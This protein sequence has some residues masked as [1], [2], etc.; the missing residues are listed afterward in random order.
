MAD[1]PLRIG[2]GYI[3]IQPRLDREALSTFKAKLIKELETAGKAGSRA[4]VNG[5]RLGMDEAMSGVIN[6]TNRAVKSFNVLSTEVLKTNAKLASDRLAQDAKV[7]AAR[8]TASAKSQATIEAARI[9]SESSIAAQQMRIDAQANESRIRRAE[10]TAKAVERAYGQALAEETRRQA[11]A[12]SQMDAFEASFRRSMQE[13]ISV[14]RQAARVQQQEATRSL[15][16]LRS[17]SQAWGT[18]ASAAKNADRVNNDLNNALKEQSRWLVYTAE[19]IRQ[20]GNRLQSFGQ[21]WTGYVTTPILGAIAAM[22]SF[23]LQAGA[24]IQ[25]SQMGLAAIYEANG[26]G[27]SKATDIAKANLADLRSFAEK[28]SYSFGDMANGVQRL[29]AAGVR[30][31]TGVEWMKTLGNAAAVSGA[32]VQE[33]NRAII[34]VTQSMDAERINAQDMNQLQNAGIPIWMVLGKIYH[35]NR[36]ELLAMSAAGQLL[37]RDVWPKVMKFWDQAYGAK[38]GK[39]AMAEA[40]AG[41]VPLESLKNQWE[42]FKNQLADVVNGQDKRGNIIDPETPRQLSLLFKNL[43]SALQA[44]VPIFKGFLKDILPPLNAGLV[45]LKGVIE[46]LQQPQNEWIRNLVLGAAV[47]GPLALGAGLMFRTVGFALGPFG[48]L[49]ELLSKNKVE[50]GK[51][52]GTFGNL[53]GSAGKFGKALLYLTTIPAFARLTGMGVKSVGKGISWFSKEATAKARFVTGMPE[54]TISGPIKR[55]GG[56]LKEDAQDAKGFFGGLIS[57][58]PGMEKAAGLLS[59]IKVLIKSPWGAAA[60]TAVIAAIAALGV[61]LVGAWKKSENFRNGIKYMWFQ[62]RDIFSRFKAGIQNAFGGNASKSLDGFG[63][64]F[65]AFGDWLEKNV[66]W[67]VNRA[68]IWIRDNFQ[69]IFAGLVLAFQTVGNVVGGILG[70]ILSGLWSILKGLGNAVLGVA[71]MVWSM[72]K[73]MLAWIGFADSASGAT[74]QLGVKGGMLGK[75]IVLLISAF[76]GFGKMLHAV[77][78]TAMVTADVL[79]GLFGI[80]GKTAQAMGQLFQGHF[81]D[82]WNTFKSGFSG[83]KDQ[84]TGAIGKIGKA[85]TDAFDFKGIWDDSAS[86]FNKLFDAAGKGLGSPSKTKTPKATAPSD[87]GGDGLEPGPSDSPSSPSSTKPTPADKRRA[88]LKKKADAAKKRFEDAKSSLLDSFKSFIDGM[89]GDSDQ[90]KKAGDALVKSVEKAFDK[91]GRSKA[92]DQAVAYLK[93]VNARLVAIAKERDAIIQKVADAKD[94][95][96]TTTEGAQDT[97]KFGNLPYSNTTSGG[98]R[99]GLQERLNKIKQFVSVIKA[100]AKRGIDKGL[101]RQVVEMGP[102]DGLSLGQTLLAADK[103]TFKAIN[104]IQKQIDQA[105]KNL[106]NTASEMIFGS[107]KELEKKGKSLQDQ[108]NKIAKNAIAA[109]ARQFGIGWKDIRSITGAGIDQ[110]NKT[111][112]DGLT[113]SKVSVQNAATAVKSSWTAMVADMNRTTG[114]MVTVTYGQGARKVVNTM[115]SIAGT[116][117]PLPDLHFSGGGVV[118]GYAPRRDIVPAMLS[119]GEGV[120]VPELT[121]QI[122]SDRLHEWNRAAMAGRNVFSTGGVVDGGSW[123][124]KHKNDPYSGYEEAM[125]AALKSVVDPSIADLRSKSPFG[126]IEGGDFKSRYP[127]LITWAKKLDKMAEGSAGGVIKI[128]R[129]EVGQGDRGGSDNN[130]NKYNQF[131]GEAWCADFISYVVDHAKANKAYWNSPSPTPQNRWPGVWNWIDHAGTDTVPL[132]KARPG[133]LATYRGD[134]HINLIV[135]VANGR[136]HAIGGNQGPLV[137]EGMYPET[138]TKILRPRFQNL[139]DEFVNPWPGSIPSNT[140]TPGAGGV[141]KGGGTPGANRTLGYIMSM[142]RGWA[143]QFSSLDS[144]WDHE[145][146]WNH[147]A[148]NPSSGAYGIPQSLPGSKMASVGPDWRTN[149]ATQITWGL[150]YISGRYKNPNNAWSWW[151]SHNWYEDGAWRVP[152]NN[153]PAILHKN[154]MVVPAR[155]AESFREALRGRKADVAGTTYDVTINAAPDVPTERTMLRAL[156]YADTMHRLK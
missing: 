64:K 44:V 126:G 132:S 95:A 90:V 92:G 138:P 110:T 74:S 134:G 82:A 83:F 112:N 149:P 77:I 42:T 145:S 119:P 71:K 142:Q 21:S 53:T 116:N 43:G 99:Q 144:L 25:K 150:N 88:A 105:S 73:Q 61:G 11:A 15:G 125:Q 7:E 10:A 16:R 104:S 19:D 40:L 151:R 3:D 87:K 48:K 94:F 84:M 35:K 152:T 66:L 67:P 76:A 135:K 128:A 102:V 30:A 103:E 91:I 155:P 107:V 56:K 85:W 121:R 45:K 93:K 114:Q 146:G 63:S 22:T 136:I 41:K 13:S 17:V 98:I 78:Q 14:Q 101:L 9:K 118:D 139:G 143:S 133:D 32:G 12:V 62:V 148:E 137:E 115:A 57:K 106:G 5:V 122:G 113:K 2:G 49:R 75:V 39:P 34:A 37:S 51:L 127:D 6:S 69:P 108:M 8:V 120:T 97:A 52:T 140:S 141:P 117:A 27:I 156:S 18:I 68:L 33:M 36:S 47:F 28:T 111:L 65:K 31:Q 46:A 23:G 58:I 147:L 123:V 1:T 70:P 24:V 80:V 129:G 50:G 20:Y 100:L 131:N 59:K 124:E 54:G 130:I 79:G 109:V 38:N 26:I 86:Q 72:I 96:K 4:L 29:A 55:V 153:H 89:K 60:V 81:G 154:E